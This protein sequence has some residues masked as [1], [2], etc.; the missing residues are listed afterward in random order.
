MRA[1]LSLLLA[2]ISLAQ[3]QSSSDARFDLYWNSRRVLPPVARLA[4][5]VNL[6]D[7]DAGTIDLTLSTFPEV[8]K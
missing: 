8:R 7:G 2:V 1:C 5:E 3:Q 6:L 4:T